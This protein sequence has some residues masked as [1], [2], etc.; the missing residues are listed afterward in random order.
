MNNK[1]DKILLNAIGN[2]KEAENRRRQGK[3]M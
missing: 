2:G 1:I 3:R